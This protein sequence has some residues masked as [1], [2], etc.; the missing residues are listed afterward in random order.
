MQTL[1]GLRVEQY[2]EHI[3]QQENHLRYARG[4]LWI[5]QLIQANE[6]TGCQLCCFMFAAFHANA[7]TPHSASRAIRFSSDRRYRHH[8]YYGKPSGVRHLY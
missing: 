2:H 4:L 1:I 6:L 5:K 8:I 7:T 3:T